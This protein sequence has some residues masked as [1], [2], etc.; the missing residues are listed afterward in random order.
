MCIRDRRS[1]LDRICMLGFYFQ[2]FEQ[3]THKF[4]WKKLTMED[5]VQTCGLY[6]R[7]F[8]TGVEEILAEFRK[9]VLSIEQ[10][11]MRDPATPLAEITASLHVFELL[12]PS[13]YGLVNEVGSNSLHGGELLTAIHRRAVCG[14][15]CVKS[16]LERLLFLCNTVW[17]NQVAS[18]MVRG[19]LVDNYDELFIQ[20]IDVSPLNQEGELQNTSSDDWS[21][22]EVREQMLPLFIPLRVAERVLF[23]GKAIRVLQHPQAKQKQLLEHSDV[24]EFTE[25]LE[26]V[27]SA[28]LNQVVLFE[29][30]VNHMRTRVARR[31]WH[32]IV[33]E[34]ELVS[35]LQQMKDFF[36]LSKGEFYDQFISDSRHLMLVP[37][38]L[39]N[40][41]SD[42]NLIFHQAAGQVRFS[43]AE[44]E[45]F[46]TM[47]L[48]LSPPED[49]AAEGEL[50]LIHISEPTRPY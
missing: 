43:A 1:V 36:F 22:F 6:L 47:R 31:L 8:C 17:F 49:S 3:F 9:T 27:R 26:K 30:S 2:Q 11:V 44:D 20:Q 34:S 40:A 14:V 28:E 35:H 39:V 5:T 16:A 50:S 23:V 15:P 10:D 45:F 42:V 46:K 41:E 25:L 24:E 37:P 48:V 29:N 12:F 21:S 18:W 7:A 19:V 33:L 4:G 32:L 13:L 38:N